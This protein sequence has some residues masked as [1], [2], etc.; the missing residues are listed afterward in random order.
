M[1]ALI[2][3]RYE[4]KRFLGEGSF[5]YVYLAHDRRTGNT[6]A[7][8]AALKD[9]DTD[10]FER[11]ADVLFA[12][13]GVRG[14]PAIYGYF[15]G[16]EFVVGTANVIVMD[17]GGEDLDIVMRSRGGRLPLET[18]LDY[19]IQMIRILADV[20]DR[21]FIHR[22]IKP[23]NFVVN[24]EGTLTLID[25]GLAK[26]YMSS[27]GQHIPYRDDKR[28]VGTARYASIN[29]LM[30]IEASRRDDLESFGYLL[31]YLFH[32]RLPW[33]G[34]QAHNER[35]KQHKILNHKMAT[36]LS[37]LFEGM[38][39]ELVQYMRYVRMLRFADRP[40]YGM[41]SRLLELALT[42]QRQKLTAA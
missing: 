3:D 6:V 32:G 33:Q 34:L 7:A 41:L 27:T 26:R 20:H 4:L 30:G 25:Y 39:H 19:G 35:S 31:V 40:D 1:L 11:E 28:L 42:A 16:C 14:V 21:R 12:L 37:T 29:M 23:E 36:G 17:Y 5:G 9:S 22:D 15:M 13:T 10:L 8:K 38:P 24:E 18:V 2:E